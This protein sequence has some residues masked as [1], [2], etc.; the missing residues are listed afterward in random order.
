MRTFERALSQHLLDDA[1]IAA[2]VNTR[3]F[4]VRLP[5]RSTLPAIAWQRA[6]TNRTYTYDR[7][8][9]AEPWASVR[10]QIDCW[11]RSPEEVIDVSEAVMFSL[12]GY[13]DLMSGELLTTSFNID[14]FDLFDS[15]TKQYRRV[16][17]FRIS[18]QDD[19]TTAS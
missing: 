14:E 8:E 4:P 16:L 9:D 19:V 7:Q 11:G 2:L 18:H 3:V 17:D 12:S 6:S 15:A 13:D 1:G 10:V 5:E